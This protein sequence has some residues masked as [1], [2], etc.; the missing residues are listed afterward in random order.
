MPDKKPNAR[1]SRKSAAIV[2]IAVVVFLLAAVT[3]LIVGHGAYLDGQQA[4]I[5]NYNTAFKATTPQTLVYLYED[6]LERV[7]LAEA[8][9][10]SKGAKFS[11]T[12]IQ[13][14][15]GTVSKASGTVIDVSVKP[16]RLAVVNVVSASGSRSTDY[17]ITVAPLS[18][19]NNVIDYNAGGGE[20]DLD[21][22]FFNYSGQ[23]DVTLPTPVKTFTGA[24]GN[25]VNFDFEGWY[26]TPDF[27]DGTEIEVIPAGTRGGVA[28][29]AKF[30]STAAFEARDGYTYVYFGKYPQRQV[31]DYSL[32]TV[33]KASTAYANAGSGSVFTYNGAEYF[34]FTPA[35][36]PNLSDNG[37]SSTSTYIFY[38]EPV[39][40]RVLKAKGASVSE[41][42]NVTLLSTSVLNCSSY[43][44]NGGTVQDLYDQYVT[45]N[46]FDMTSFL[47]YFYH[48]DTMYERSDVK[49]AVDGMYSMMFNGVDSGPVRS[50]SLTKYN[51][52]LGSATSSYNV[53][54]WLPNYDEVLNESYG[55]NKDYTVNDNLRKA[56]VTDFGAAN[57]VYR[58]TSRAHSGQGTWWLRGAGDNTY[59]YSDK[60]IA[61]VKYTGYVHAYGA[62]NFEVRS[63]IRPAMNIAY[64]SSLKG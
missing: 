18:A 27:A 25:T 31:T 59:S 12:K 53:N 21:D 1:I 52:F 35:N 20:I 36:V 23:L 17:R 6:G 44:A 41:G 30:A 2:V 45:Q 57:G 56:L 51:D 50:R 3:A 28:V 64:T 9:E 19:E 24:S 10:V 40:W 7:D 4:L 11:V 14:E 63:G 46:N 37:Y 61:Y 49:K 8:I 58:A 5:T 38:V 33:L 34:K 13:D 48:S 42:E 32:V 43:S 15:D 39:E 60:R 47:R 29:Y 16:Q 55:F 54:M 26:T 22:I 62:M